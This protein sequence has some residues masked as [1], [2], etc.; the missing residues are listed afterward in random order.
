MIVFTC[1]SCQ[2][3]YSMSDRAVGQKFHCEACGQRVQVPDPPAESQSL[4]SI[5]VEIK[6]QSA[7]ETL[8][9]GKRLAIVGTLAMCAAMLSGGLLFFALSMLLRSTDL[10]DLVL[11]LAMSVS[12]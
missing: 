8:Q 12:Q 2:H 4:H 5:H 10:I 1:P 9:R 7:M 11:S 3:T 6:S